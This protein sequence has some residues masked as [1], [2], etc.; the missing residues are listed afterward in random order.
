MPASSITTIEHLL[1]SR[2]ES[3]QWPT[4]MNAQ[5]VEQNSHHLL[6][7]LHIQPTLEY[8]AGHFPEQ[9]VLPGVVQVHWAG[10][11][12]KHAFDLKSFSALQGAK[13]NTMVLPDSTLNL[14]LIFKADKLSV[15][16]AYFDAD[17]RYSQGKLVFS[18][19][20]SNTAID[21]TTAQV[22]S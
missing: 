11:L 18:D 7:E 9:P 21:M 12:A 5:S 15:Q 1:V 19:T 2:A 4:L 6:L 10:E 3:H 8:F 16:F 14:E 17:Q 13:F 20:A 22:T